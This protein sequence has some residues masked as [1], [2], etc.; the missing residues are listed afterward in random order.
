MT[1]FIE[2]NCGSPFIYNV[3]Q[4]KSTGV[5]SN[6][7]T[8]KQCLLTQRPAQLKEKYLIIERITNSSMPK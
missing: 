4:P 2:T 3:E 1:T 6:K 5:D 7:T 8:Q